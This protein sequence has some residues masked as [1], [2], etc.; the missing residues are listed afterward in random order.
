[1]NEKL[2][3]LIYSKVGLRW[4][5]EDKLGHSMR[6][7]HHQTTFFFFF[8]FTQWDTTVLYGDWVEIGEVRQEDVVCRQMLF[9]QRVKVSKGDD[10][11]FNLGWVAICS[12]LI[13][14][15]LKLE[16]RFFF[17]MMQQF[18]L[19]FDFPQV[20]PWLFSYFSSP[21]NLQFE[22]TWFLFYYGNH[23]KRFFLVL[24]SPTNTTIECRVRKGSFSC[25][26]KLFWVW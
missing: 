15:W 12:V 7:N 26:S 13:E 1:M 22:A 18:V 9:V 3:K 14:S 11:W 5:K 4:K 21:F 25:S 10:V 17:L 16:M 6:K 24:S 23:T 8:S 19:I 2:G 20:N